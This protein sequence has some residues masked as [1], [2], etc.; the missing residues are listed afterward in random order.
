MDVDVRYI[1]IAVGQFQQP[2]APG[3]GVP[4]LHVPDL[5][6]D[7]PAEVVNGFVPHF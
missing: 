4:H 7:L 5:I 2:Y 3:L 1:V 6:S